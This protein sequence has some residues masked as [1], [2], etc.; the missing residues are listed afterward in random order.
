MNFARGSYPRIAAAALLSPALLAILL[1][2]ADLALLLVY[3]TQPWSNPRSVV[4]V[5]LWW[6][7]AAVVLVAI[8][9]ILRKLG[10]TRLRHHLLA[11]LT[12]GA[13]PL[14]GTLTQFFSAVS[15]R[16]DATAQGPVA[17]ADVFIMVPYPCAELVRQET[18]DLP[19]AVHMM[20]SASLLASIYKWLAHGM[21]GEA[22]TP[23]WKVAS[24]VYIVVW[25]LYLI[26]P[27]HYIYRSIPSWTGWVWKTC[28]Y[29]FS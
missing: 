8:G 21:T 26:E 11:G 19:G 22:T 14:I 27:L 18:F 23:T 25:V 24:G 12:I 16:A 13:I 15:H 9:I 4:L 10:T 5:L 7:G 29:L 6:S 20:L 17:G 1:L 3:R 28:D 2:A